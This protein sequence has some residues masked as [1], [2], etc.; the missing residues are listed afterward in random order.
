MLFVDSV[1]VN[2]DVDEFTVVD[3]RMLRLLLLRVRLKS[4]RNVWI[5]YVWVGD[6]V[7]P[8]GIV[9]VIWVLVTGRPVNVFPTK[10][11]NI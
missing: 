4:F 3:N 10:I 2:E 11:P 8:T 6:R 5:V 9:L 1:V 7:R